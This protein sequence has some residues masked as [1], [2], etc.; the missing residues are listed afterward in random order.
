M[1][2]IHFISYASNQFSNRKQVLENT[3][4]DSNW[5]DTY[6]IKTNDD[7][8]VEFKQKYNDIMCR[9]HGDGFWLWKS[10]IIKNLLEDT[11]EGDIIVYTDAGCTLNLIEDSR[12]NFDRYINICKEHDLLRFELEHPEYKYTNKKTLEFFKANYGL[13]KEHVL[14]NQL[15]GGILVM[16]NNSKVKMF[17]DTFFKI[18]DSDHNLITNKYTH[19]DNYDGFI[20]HRYD[21][22]ILSLLSKV[23][24]VGYIIPDE[25][26]PNNSKFQTWSDSVYFPFLATRSK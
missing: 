20:D 26:Y 4:N 12:F 23:T 17:F 1:N 13:K 25:S 2:K 24:G 14:S 21:Q 7:L 19:E 5:F 8:S 11:N 6:Q 15:V 16:E 3:L 10:E 18:I 9:D 22:S